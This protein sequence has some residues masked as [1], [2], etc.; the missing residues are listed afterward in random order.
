LLTLSNVI[1]YLCFIS[2]LEAGSPDALTLS[3]GKVFNE[4]KKDH[5]THQEVKQLTAGNNLTERAQ[6]TGKK[7]RQLLLHNLSLGTA[8]INNYELRYDF[9]DSEQC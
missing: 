7:G 8:H 6:I 2:R 5:S 4:F 3:S 1:C 9:N